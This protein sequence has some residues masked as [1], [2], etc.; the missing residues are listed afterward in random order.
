MKAKDC[1]RLLIAK[2]YLLQITGVSHRWHLHHRVDRN[3]PTLPVLWYA[4]MILSRWF[5]I[6]RLTN[7]LTGGSSRS[8]FYQRQQSI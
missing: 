5:T 7:A 3:L 2:K 4:W 1:V 8:G 6:L